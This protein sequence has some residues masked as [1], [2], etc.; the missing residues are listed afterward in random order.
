MSQPEIIVYSSADV[1]NIPMADDNNT[2]T[3]NN[4]FSQEIVGTTSGNLKDT[5]DT[6]TGTYNIVGTL[7]TGEATTNY[8]EFESD[9][10]MVANGTA[11]TWED[12]RFPATAIN[13][14]GAPSA[15]VFDTTNIGF[16][17][18]AGGTQVIAII[19]QMPHSWKVG[20][21]IHPHIHWEPITTNTGDVLWRLEYKWTNIGDT[22]PANF[23]TVD[24][25]D[26]GDGTALKH[27]LASFT[28]LSGA[29]KTLSSI[30]SMK[31]SRIGGDGTDTFTGDALLK[32]FDIH[33][34]SDTLG[35]RSELSK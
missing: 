20:S 8:T 13:P 11:T 1:S 25:L 35:S 33:Y 29:G 15:M 22:E 21:D 12:L 31:I 24:V 28:A 30:L 34:E 19:G 14:A 3:G 5:G 26:A 9:G 4:T 27:Q 18:G 23:T 2:F 32:E 10:T 17:A 6:G 7:K 16:T